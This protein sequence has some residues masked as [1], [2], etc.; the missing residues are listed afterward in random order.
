MAQVKSD[1]NKLDQ[2]N[3]NFGSKLV[4]ASIVQHTVSYK[5]NECSEIEFTEKKRGLPEGMERRLESSE[6]GD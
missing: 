1:Q 3:Y 6:H 2:G 4:V 5:A